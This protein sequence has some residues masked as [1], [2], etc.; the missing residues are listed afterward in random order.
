MRGNSRVQFLWQRD[1]FQKVIFRVLIYHDITR[2]QQKSFYKQIKYLK[3]NCNVISLSEFV[4]LTESG[5]KVEENTVAVTFDDAF[6][7]VYQYAAPI[8]DDFCIKPC[9]FV[10]VGFIETDNKDDYVRQK[11]GFSTGVPM[12]WENI[13]E[14]QQ[15]GYEIAAHSWNHVDFSDEKICCLS[16]IF[17]E[18]VLLEKKLGKNVL[19]F[20]FPFGRKECISDAVCCLLK[21]YG[22]VRAFSGLKEEITDSSFCLPRT[23]INPVWGAPELACM[24][25]GYFD[26]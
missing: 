17:N 25:R 10:P 18:K 7:G 21:K 1:L 19:Y 12:S 14:L 26:A 20:A 2:M 9:L 23:Y 24:L 3:E 16:E 22:Y 15:R 13:I 4:R 5:T 11:I 8:L 6:N